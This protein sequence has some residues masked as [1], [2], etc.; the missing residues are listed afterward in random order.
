MPLITRDEWLEIDGIPL[1]TPAWEILDLSPLEDAAAQR[2]Q[3]R[4]IPGAAGVIPFPRRKTVTVRSLQMVILG[5]FDQEGVAT[6][7]TGDGSGEAYR[8]A[9]RIRRAANKDY[10]VDNLVTPPGTAD[11]TRAAVLNRVDG[12]T[13]SADVHVIGPMQLAPIGWLGYRAVLTLSI[14]TGELV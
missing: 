1:A 5:T 6:C 8:E 7:A 12:S 3:D 4:L 9:V 2:G 14:P 10:L 11:G 13:W